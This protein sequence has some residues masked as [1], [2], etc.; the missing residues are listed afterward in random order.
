VPKNLE[1]ISKMKLIS[2]LIQLMAKR[3]STLLVDQTKEISRLSLKQ[4][5]QTT[6][7]FLTSQWKDGQFLSLVSQSHLQMEHTF[8]LKALSKWEI[9][10]HLIWLN[11]MKEWFYPLSIM[12]SKLNSRRNK[13]DKLNKNLMKQTSSSVK[14]KLILEFRNRC[15]IKSMDKL[16]LLKV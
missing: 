2:P 4:S 6:A 7:Q 13:E 3:M 16:L 14:L 8:S 1:I 5:L 9:T 15:S 11:Y 12:N 10:C